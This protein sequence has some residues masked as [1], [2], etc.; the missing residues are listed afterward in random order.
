MSDDSE[1]FDELK[2]L[3]ALKRHEAA[4]P[5]FFQDLPGRVLNQIEAEQEAGA[6]GWWGRLMESFRV[7]PAFS[8]AF[9]MG[10][11][12]MLMA[13]VYYGS[14]PGADSNGSVAT[15]PVGTGQLVADNPFNTTN[16]NQTSPPS[17][18]FDPTVGSGVQRASR[19]NTS[20]KP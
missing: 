2:R 18:M 6:N 15:D 14:R 4:P 3:L 13:A 7:R 12:A 8:G 9:A 19:T 5:G 16:L 20:T 17:G 10:L 11:C 1:N